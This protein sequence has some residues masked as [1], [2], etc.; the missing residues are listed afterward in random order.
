M[1]TADNPDDLGT[2]RSKPVE[3]AQSTLSWN[4]PTWICNPPSTWPKSNPLQLK[5]PI[6]KSKTIHSFQASVEN[7][8]ILLRFSSYAKYLRILL[9]LSTRKLLAP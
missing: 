6:E 8:D 1:P 2:R 7:S 9:A 5:E 4:G 3:I